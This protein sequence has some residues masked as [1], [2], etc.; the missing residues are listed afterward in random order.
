MCLIVLRQEYTSSG[1]PTFSD[2]KIHGKIVA[3]GG[4]SWIP[5]NKAFSDPMCM[6]F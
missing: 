3:S 1:C 2:A 4:D 5:P 6:L